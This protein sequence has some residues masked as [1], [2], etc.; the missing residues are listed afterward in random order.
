[1]LLVCAPLAL[2]PVAHA[3]DHEPGVDAAICRELLLGKTPAEIATELQRGSPQWST[4]QMLT[5][6]YDVMG[7][8]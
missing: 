1:V 8:C 4:G 7:Y 5:T 6:V 3:D 2:V